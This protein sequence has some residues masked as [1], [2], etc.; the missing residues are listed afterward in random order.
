MHIIIDK[1]KSRDFSNFVEID[2][3]PVD[4][5][6]ITEELA[7]AVSKAL[8]KAH[9]KTIDAHKRNMDSYRTVINQTEKEEDKAYE[10]LSTGAVDQNMYQRQIETIRKKKRHYENLL[11]D[12]QVLITTKFYETSDT[13]LELTKNAKSLWK[14]RSDEEKLEFLK[15]IL[16]N[17]TLNTSA[18]SL[19]E[20]SIEYDLKESF[21][22]LAKIKKAR[23][24]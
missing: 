22:E 19:D 23:M 17:Q 6:S 8:K 9:D 13:I 16:S 1:D 11:E 5:I 21:K 20:V 15:L 14:E 4:E 24:G 10:L 2:L 3:T 18:S 7:K 12:G